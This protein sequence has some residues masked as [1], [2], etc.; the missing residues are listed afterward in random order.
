MGGWPR[1]NIPS[2]ETL[3]SLLLASLLLEK[4]VRNRLQFRIPLISDDQGNIL[5]M[6]NQ[7]ARKMPTMAILM[8]LVLSLHQGGCQLAPSHV[9]SEKG[10]EYLGG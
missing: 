2:L 9:I 4:G 1:A 3:D 6:L 5:T 10:L 7:S 8:Q